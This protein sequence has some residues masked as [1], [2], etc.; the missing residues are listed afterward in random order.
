M[1][2]QRQYVQAVLKRFHMDNCDGCAT[3]E[4]STPSKVEIPASKEYLPYRELVGAFQYLVNASR[5]D[6]AH[7]ARYL[8]KYLACYD[9]THYAQA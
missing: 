9:H 8:G 5:P 2:C 3:P 6:I 7:A 4:A 1:Y